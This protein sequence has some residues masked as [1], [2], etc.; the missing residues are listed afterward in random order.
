MR[1][2]A[3]R[4]G[5]DWCRLAIGAVVLAIAAGAVAAGAGP[6]HRKA[7]QAVPPDAEGRHLFLKLWPVGEASPTGGDGLG[8]LYNEGSCVACHHVGGLGGAGLN[9]R[10]VKLLVASGKVADQVNNVFQGEL[11]DLHPGFRG[12]TSVVLHKHGTTRAV[13]ERLREIGSYTAIRTPDAT[14]ALRTTERNTPPLFGAGLIDGILD[15]ALLDASAHRDEAFPEVKGRVSRLGDGRIGR[16]GWKGQVATLDDFVRAACANELGLELP[17]RHQA[18]L[19]PAKEFDPKALKP[20]MEDREVRLLFGFVRSLPRPGFRV[21]AEVAM[22]RS[23]PGKVD[24]V[25]GRAVFDRIGCA[26]C[27]APKLGE[28]DG[29]YSDLLLHDL[30]ARLVDAGT[31]YGDSSPAPAPP[32]VLASGPAAAGEWRTPPLWGVASSAPYLHDGRAATLSE[33][34]GLHG[35]EAEATASRYAALPRAEQQSL[36]AFLHSLQAPPRDAAPVRPAPRPPEPPARR[37]RTAA[38]ITGFP[39]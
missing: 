37:P 5:G 10:N 25:R 1:C 21:P 8:P 36:L 30:G 31:Y 34:I 14:T 33:A 11:T 39:F 38:F 7:A 32:G 9:D 20:D 12:G 13:E 17:G 4:F 23:A 29:L 6:R 16:F 27:H 22:L 19:T 24:P 26:T 28:V 3:R 2:D 15:R 35:G 18:S